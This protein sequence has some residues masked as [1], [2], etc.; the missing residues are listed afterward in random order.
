MGTVSNKKAESGKKSVAEI[1]IER[2]LKDVDEK[3]KMPWQRPYERYNAFNYFSMKAYRGINR[4]ILPFGE[5]MTRNQITKYNKDRGYIKT[6]ASG[7]VVEVTPEAYKFQKGILWYPVVFFKVLSKPVSRSDVADVFP[8][9]DL[10]PI[11]EG[12]VSNIG[13][14]KSGYTYKKIGSH[15]V[16]EKNIL[17]YSEVADRSHFRNSRGEMLPSRLETKDVVIEKQKP[18][19][20]VE[21]YIRREGIKVDKEYR[22]VPCY[23]PALDKVCLNPTTTT[24]EAWFSVA[25]HELG[26]STGA[27]T[28]LNRVGVAGTSTNKDIYAKEECIAEI[29][30]CLCCAETGVDTFETSGTQTYENS[31]AYV[32]A[33]KERVKDWGKDFI[34]IV[35]EAD[36]AFN[37]ICSNPDS[38][39]SDEGEGTTGE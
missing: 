28:R 29:C 31:I 27:E 8:D 25:F 39:M 11:D 7:K 35:S 33:W 38:Y 37:Y 15:F 6:D 30:A 19:D 2:F 3:E 17:R 12:M 13:R 14:D 32:Q 36:K 10:S 4:L 16:K 21:N 26:H 1:I 23:I 5:Y 20:V 18:K 22:G 34:Y 24:E 9:A